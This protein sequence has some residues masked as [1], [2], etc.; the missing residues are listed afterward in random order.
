M[1]TLV[2]A[3][4][5]CRGR[6]AHRRSTGIALLF[7]DQRHWKWVRGQPHAPAAFY[8][9]ERPGSHC[10]GGWVGPR[11][12]LDRCE[13]FCLHWDFFCPRFYCSIQ[14]ICYICLADRQLGIQ[15]L[16]SQYCYFTYF[17][18]LTRYYAPFFRLSTNYLCLYQ[19]SADLQVK[20]VSSINMHFVSCVYATSSC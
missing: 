10:T 4:R 6:T 19:F 18:V 14:S 9:R 20:G 15:K 5:L 1:C 2:Q 12:S 11:T 8:P 16:R 13:K 7:H 3:L 17:I